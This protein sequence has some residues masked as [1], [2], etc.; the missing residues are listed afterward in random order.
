MTKVKIC[1]ITTLQEI[2]FV[3]KYKPDFAG[4]VMFF[5]KS[6]RNID[7]AT[8]QNL[9]ANLDK[10]IK[11]VA[12][13]VTPDIQQIN[14]AKKVGFNYV[15][16]HGKVENDLLEKSP[17][18]VLRAFNVSDIEKFSEYSKFDNI[19]GYLFD[20]AVPGSGKKF[21]WSLLD[22]IDRDGK[23]FFLAGGL[24]PENVADAI[25]KVNPDGVDVS[26]GVEND[27]GIGKNEEK[28]KTFVSNV[29]N[30]DL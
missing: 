29:R 25:A 6:K 13:M 19:K 2:E 12:V 27:N 24:N 11:S 1:G 21:D 16:I 7:T 8:A 20:S 10:S 18:P 14:A 17:L 4:F 15:Q 3:N 23:M 26:S 30:F 22:K 9:L 28:I 5:Q